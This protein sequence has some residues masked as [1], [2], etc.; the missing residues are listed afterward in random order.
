MQRALLIL[1]ALILPSYALAIGEQYGRLTG[2]IY[3][4]EGEEAPGVAVTITS[5]ALT[6]PRKTISKEDGSFTFDILPPGTYYLTAEKE[7]KEKY[8][9]EGIEIHVGKTASIY[10]VIEPAFIPHEGIS[11]EER[12]EIVYYSGMTPNQRTVWATP[13]SI[14]EHQDAVPKPPI[15]TVD[16]IL[17]IEFTQK[18]KTG[19]ARRLPKLAK[20]AGPGLETL[21]RM[22]QEVSARQETLLAVAFL[23][24]GF[25]PY[26]TFAF[27]QFNDEV[28]IIETG[29]T[30]SYVFSKKVSRVS[31]EQFEEFVAQTTT[32][33]DCHMTTEDS[34]DDISLVAWNESGV[35]MLCDDEQ[36][37]RAQL[38]RFARVL[39][40]LTADATTTHNRDLLYQLW[41]RLTRKSQTRRTK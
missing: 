35:P 41:H 39:E 36:D 13:G 28:Y 4:E 31:L 30:W 25:H 9:L 18:T 8:Q 27:I 21:T 16:D 1:L 15:K 34:L 3:T 5:K 17:A 10:V 38:E 11:K 7:G 20:E 22:R 33:M 29:I 14:N 12:D 6:A 32:I 24:G 19:E 37:I 2:I 40:T 23:P 26:W